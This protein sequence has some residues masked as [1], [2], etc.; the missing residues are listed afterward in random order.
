MKIRKITLINNFLK[1]QLIII[2]KTNKRKVDQ[3]KIKSEIMTE[4]EKVFP[5]WNELYKQP[6]ESMPWFN[7]DL[8]A[9]LENVLD[10]AKTT[11]DSI[12]S[13][14]KPKSVPRFYF[15]VIIGIVVMVILFKLFS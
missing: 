14:G 3:L 12:F 1:N 8:D 13:S 11:K 5:N 4:S 2:K 9:D 7:K 6:V 10:G 15:A